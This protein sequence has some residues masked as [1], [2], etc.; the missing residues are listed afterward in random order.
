[1][2]SSWVIFYYVIQ[3]K[4]Q[5]CDSDDK[6]AESEQITKSHRLT[7]KM[8]NGVNGDKGNK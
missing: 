4:L 2:F 5:Y 1:M 8:G 6:T 7:A 3:F